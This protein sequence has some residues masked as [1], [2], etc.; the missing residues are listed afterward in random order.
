MKKTVKIASLTT[1]LPAGRDSNCENHVPC[2]A[3]D[4]AP[5]AAQER[6]LWAIHTLFFILF[7]LFIGIVPGKVVGQ[8]A[9]AIPCV[10]NINDY[11][12]ITFGTSPS[13]VSSGKLLP[14]PGSAST[15]PQKLIVASY[16]EFT[17]AYEFAPGTEIVMLPNA[18][19]WIRNDVR[20][21]GQATIR[22]CG[23]SWYGIQT[24]ANGHISIYNSTIS[25]SCEGIILESGAKGQIVGNTFMD[26]FTCIQAEGSVILYSEGIA[27]NIFDGTINTNSGCSQLTPAAIR[28]IN[29]PHITI[30]DLTQT[31]NPNRIIGYASGIRA[32]NS[33]V[34]VVNTTF[35][36]K[37]TGGGAIFLR[38]TSGV[39]TASVTGLGSDASSPLFLDNYSGG[40]DARNYNLSVKD[41][42]FKGVDWGVQLFNSTLPT[43]LNLSNNLIEN[44]HR[45]AVWVTQSSLGAADITKN[46]TWDN[47]SSPEGE[48][49]WIRWSNTPISSPTRR[50]FIHIAPCIFKGTKSV[51]L[52]HF[53][54]EKTF[55]FSFV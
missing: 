44:Y 17:D 53:E 33:N 35:A 22:G 5:P 23:G 25:N 7:G 45:Y 1:I 37:P 20:F 2:V 32:N 15:Q 14:Y 31:G 27:H 48:R 16:I 13:L 9:P 43:T 26:N 30:G 12:C 49:A 47:S 28:L 4:I 55:K 3:G 40:I 36:E 42:S 54:H 39:F 34:D 41:A 24:D 50:A 19:L 18:L 11:Q 29:V 8:C 6:K 10:Q 46:E 21:L 51:S 52:L 38:G